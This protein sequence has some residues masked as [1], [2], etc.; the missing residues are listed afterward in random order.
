MRDAAK[1]A[2]RAILSLRADRLSD[3]LS[4]DS[5]NAKC[6]STQRGTL[7]T[8]AKTSVVEHEPKSRVS[9]LDYAAPAV[10]FPRTP[11]A[12]RTQLRAR[13]ARN[14]GMMVNASGI[15]WWRYR[16][17]QRELRTPACELAYELADIVCTGRE[18][19]MI[20]YDSPRK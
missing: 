14:S 11:Y 19:A 12:L 8:G 18:F 10:S 3:E 9:V 20:N 6:R 17:L 5:R 4:A 15:T 13:S 2:R 16:R 7:T 1:A